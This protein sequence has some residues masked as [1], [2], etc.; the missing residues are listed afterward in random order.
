[1][2]IFDLAVVSAAETSR[3]V[4]DGDPDLPDLTCS[5]SPRWD[6]TR[7]TSFRVAE[8]LENQDCA[9]LA[10]LLA[11]DHMDA[12]TALVFGDLRSALADCPFGVASV[13]GYLMNEH[14]FNH[15]LTYDAERRGAPA[16]I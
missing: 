16:G 5:S 3:Y 11:E 13:A 9:K 8:G 1:M 7:K 15:T 4:Y 12:I 10:C 2:T 14:L 6:E